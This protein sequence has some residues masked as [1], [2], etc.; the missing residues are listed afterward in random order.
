MIIK[1]KNF[2][3][4]K[5]IK[6]ISVFFLLLVGLTGCEEETYEVGALVAPTNL[7]V[8]VQ[9][10]GQDD[11]NPNGDGSAAVIFTATSENEINY[12]FNFGD[13]SSAVSPTGVI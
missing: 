8:S 13:G 7:N 9:I 5:L 12:Q 4:K 11:N 1:N 10:V 3:M 6:N 2:K